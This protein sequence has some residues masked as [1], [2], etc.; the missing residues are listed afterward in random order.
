LHSPETVHNRG[1]DRRLGHRVEHPGTSSQRSLTLGWTGLK[2]TQTHETRQEQ[3][4]W[5]IKYVHGRA[6]TVL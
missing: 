3:N 4:H 6:N 2:H 5:N 1:L